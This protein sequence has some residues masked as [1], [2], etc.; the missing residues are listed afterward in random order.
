MALSAAVER[1]IAQEGLDLLADTLS[2]QSVV[3]EQRQPAE[4]TNAIGCAGVC[5]QPVQ[6]PGR[7]PL[8]DGWER[9]ALEI[10]SRPV[11]AGDDDFARGQ[12]RRIVRHGAGG[13]G[14]IGIDVQVADIW[15]TIGMR[16]A[17]ANDVL[18]VFDHPSARLPNGHDQRRE[19]APSPVFSG[20]AIPKLPI[21]PVWNTLGRTS[22][23]AWLPVLAADGVMSR[24]AS[25]PA[26]PAELVPG[27]LPFG[28]T[29]GGRPFGEGVRVR[30]GDSGGSGGNRPPPPGAI[31]VG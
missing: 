27:Q 21:R 15:H 17:V 9:I 28:L 8:I 19:G 31:R 1:F 4:R 20:G 7:H 13:R 29:K 26:E 3:V 5:A 10:V 22:V 24:C 6:A 11:Q 12:C 30:P 2:D 23:R 25:A 18:E 14:G 16:I